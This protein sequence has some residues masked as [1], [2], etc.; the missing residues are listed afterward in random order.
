MI[1]VDEVGRGC[2]A[3]PVYAAA[4]CIK[5][6]QEFSG[7]VDSKTLSEKRRQS[8]KIEIEERYAFGIGSASVEEIDELN[9]LNATFL[10][11][12]RALQNGGFSTG[13]VLVD[14]HMKIRELENLEQTPVVKG[15]SRAHPIAAASIIAKV[16]RD[17]FMKDLANEFS[18]YGFEKHKGY[19]TKDHKSAIARLGPTVWHR[20]TFAGVR[21]HL[22]KN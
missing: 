14:G 7:L 15:D 6:G 2:L 8:L 19:S 9:I 22:S 4:V 17:E 16:T 5:P 21:E 20:K 3:G 13:H 1:G 12:R 11:M 10:A 18:G